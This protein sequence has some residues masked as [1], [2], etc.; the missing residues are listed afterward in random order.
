MHPEI[1]VIIPTFNAERTID[2]CIGSC[3]RQQ[4]LHE[5]EY[6]V[7]VVNDGSI[8]NT[9]DL[10]H[11]WEEITSGKILRVI[12]QDNE[13]AQVAF[14][15]GLEKAMG[16]VVVLVD[17]DDLLEGTALVQLWKSINKS[18]VV[19][20]V[21][22]HSGFDGKSGK[23]MFTTDKSKFL[24]SNNGNDNPLLHACG[25]G[26]PKMMSRLAVEAAG[27]FDP[28]NVAYDYDLIL[29][30]LFPGETRPWVLVDDNLYWYRVSN[31]SMSVTRRDEQIEGAVS[32]LNDALDRLGI[33]GEAFYRGRDSTGYLSYDWK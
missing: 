8:D 13:G 2:S 3:I 20:A 29:Q 23:I 30:L 10:L 1:S 19:L 5:V 25:I 6:E 7:V 33:T 31:D 22:Q 18:G 15:H 16:E 14:N 28:D 24:I 9:A 4:G 21:G 11:R 26:H 32:S 27:G 12:E 17:S